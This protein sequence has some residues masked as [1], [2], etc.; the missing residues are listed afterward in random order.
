MSKKIIF[1]LFFIFSQLAH[2]EVI[3]QCPSVDE[4]KTGK[5]KTF[6]W[7]PLYIDTEE[8]ASDA[9]VAIFAKHLDTFEVARWKEDYLENGHC[10]Y[11]GSDPMNDKITYIH[12][13]TWQP[14][15]P[16]KWNW[17]TPNKFAECYSQNPADCAFIMSS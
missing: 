5:F 11:H 4:I 9:D 8:L 13:D 3:D 1:M 15:L 17:V 12:D 10:F 2:A 16:G 6:G 14:K 7:L